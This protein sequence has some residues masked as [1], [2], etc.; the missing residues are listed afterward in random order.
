MNHP[1]RSVFAQWPLLLREGE[2]VLDDL[3]RLTEVNTIEL[4]NFDL[5]WGEVDSWDSPKPPAPLALPPYA[6]FEGLAV[7]L[8]DESAWERIRAATELIREHGFSP[9]A[10]VAPL[11]LAEPELV[12]LACVD[13]TG[14]PVP[15]IRSSLA[16][17]GC[18]NNPEVLAYG[19]AMMRGFATWWTAADAITLNHV[20]LPF[21]P[22]ASMSE[23]F[24]CFC[25]SCRDTAERSGLD[26]ERIHREVVSV[27]DLLS[28]RRFAKPGAPV[29][30]GAAE[31]V[32]F[33][34][35]RPQLVE[36]LN[37]RL[38][39][40]SNYILQVVDA[41][42]EAAGAHNPGLQVGLEFQAPTVSP[43]VGTDFREVAPLF[44]WVSPKFPV[45]LAGEVVPRI[46]DEVAAATGCWRAA[47]LD[48]GMRALLLLGRGPDRYELA[49]EPSE[50]IRYRNA[51]DHEMV[52]LQLAVLGDFGSQPVYPY[53]WKYA[54][55]AAD[56]AAKVAAIRRH[57]FQ[58]YF[59]W[60]WD[61]D[62]S[63][64]ALD[65]SAEVLPPS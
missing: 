2:R 38:S 4:S 42:R 64:E 7:P 46:A 40:L 18:P 61:T 55:D 54:G 41:A 45:Y 13:V 59:S 58:G 25:Q 17:Y 1:P 43:L 39:S 65:A 50:G 47:D 37:F 33:L 23:L 52:D 34:I 15:A 24:V 16:V 56:F 53:L 30:L 27:Y 31:L 11:Y 49:E 62:L 9:A 14:K 36:W 12:S 10:N 35:E 21:W 26:F 51:Y 8:L 63:T 60:V 20:E 22:Q 28:R 57:G 32:T 19:E 6:D 3:T 29:H 44:D 5:D 48:T